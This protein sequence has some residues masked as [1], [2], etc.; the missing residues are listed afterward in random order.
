[1][2]RILIILLI[3]TQYSV[4]QLPPVGKWR[5]HFNTNNAIDVV[6]T[7]N[8]IFVATPGLIYSVNKD[9]ENI[10]QYSKINGLTEATISGIA[11]NTQQK[12]LIIAYKNGNID[13]LTNNGSIVN[14]NDFKRSTISL[15]K[16]I[17]KLFTNDKF[18]FACTIFGIV[19]IDLE[20]METKDTWFLGSTGGFERVNNLSIY[21]G[22]YYAAT[23]NGLKS[24]PA[25]ATAIAN[26]ANWQLVNGFSGN[27]QQVVAFQNGIV[28]Q[29]NDSLYK[30]D[31]TSI[32][33]L[34]ANGATIRNVSANG[35]SLVVC[36]VQN[37]NGSIIILEAN[38]VI[39]RTISQ[40]G[41]T[42]FPAQAI[43][44]ENLL[45]V[46]DEFASLSSFENNTLKKH[47]IF[48]T[49]T[50]NPTGQML[51]ANNQL[52]VTGGGVNNLWQYTY[53][54]SGYAGFNNEQWNIKNQYS[55]TILDTVY[56]IHTVA[57]N[58]ITNKL[59]LG[60]YGGGLVIDD[61]S[62]LT[63][64]K[65]TVLQPAIGDPTNYRVGGIAVDVDGNTWVTNYGSLNT[66][67]CIKPN[68]SLQ[69]FTVPYN[70]VD[71][72]LG[73]IAI[74]EYNQKWITSPRGGG[75]VCLYTGDDVANTSDDRWRLFKTGNSNGNL[76]D[77]EVT[78]MVV[79]KQGS[80]WVGTTNG[81]SV[82]ACAT[83][84]FN[85]NIC[86]AYQ[87]VVQAGNFAGFLLQGQLI[88]SIAVDGANRK[89]LATQNGVFLVSA[90]GEKILQQFTVDN[91]PLSTNNIQSIGIHG[92]T[93]EVFFGTEIGMVSYVADATEA[94]EQFE[95]VKIFPNPVP[96][97]YGGNIAVQGLAKNALIKIISTDGTL[98]WQGVANGG[99]I[100][101]NGKNY[102]GKQIMPGMYLILMRNTDGTEKEV[103]K[104]AI[105]K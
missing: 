102:L 90:E 15:N 105:L 13:V 56:D 47:Y 3:I 65:Q 93:G 55:N 58:S 40:L 64:Q 88:Q 73:Q 61:N 11:Y 63:L 14:I 12:A 100:S 23:N 96:K 94:T 37:N 1:M 21:N 62:N 57:F 104:L 17:Y 6:A 31:G 48:Y 22:R 83:E 29:R 39:V 33:F 70:F 97:N 5:Q 53:N 34:F 42:P 71:N 69:R 86:T 60:S 99:T 10:T 76:S 95:N 59:Y 54:R 44:N 51:Y 74:D 68:G 32:T 67:L 4:A 72:A 91:S 45:W 92:K 27:I 85:N 43:I 7:E 75:V 9:D 2:N 50:S 89:W 49:L 66:L 20:R 46:A 98:V 77:N 35:T 41:V 79:D 38:G 18:V 80:V 26:G 8:N 25:N 87:P 81:I 24:I 36:T 30:Y 82:I 103:G 52:Y 78:A 84:V 19:Q 28:L 16:T 101:W